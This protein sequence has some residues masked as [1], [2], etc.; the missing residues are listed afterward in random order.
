M[1]SVGSKM[2]KRTFVYISLAVA[3]LLAVAAIGI[4]ISVN[5]DSADSVTELTGPTP[6]GDG[7]VWEV[8]G[9]TLM[10]TYTGSGTGEVRSS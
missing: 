7:V 9:D 8:I 1:E 5:N 4:L 3:I 10:V 6:C 2:N